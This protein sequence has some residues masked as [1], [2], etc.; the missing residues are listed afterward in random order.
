MNKFIKWNQVAC[1]VLLILS[2][3]SAARVS[4][5]IYNCSEVVPY[6]GDAFFCGYHETRGTVLFRS[7]GRYADAT[8]IAGNQRAGVN[9]LGAWPSGIFTLNGYLYYVAYDSQ[10][11][12]GLWRTDGKQSDPTLIYAD[13]SLAYA[14][15]VLRDDERVFLQTGSA[16]YVTG[17]SPTNTRKLNA[18]VTLEVSNLSTYWPATS[19]YLDGNT[20]WYVTYNQLHKLDLNANRSLSVVTLPVDSDNR[21]GCGYDTTLIAE[22]SAPDQIVMAHSISGCV[23][24]GTDPVELWISDGTQ[25]GTR[26]LFAEDTEVL[27][28]WQGDSLLCSLLDSAYYKLSNG[29][30]I[31]LAD[32]VDGGSECTRAKRG[33]NTNHRGTRYWIQQ[34]DSTSQYLLKAKNLASGESLTLLSVD[35][36]VTHII[37]D[38]NQLYLVLRDESGQYQLS[39]FSLASKE[40]THLKSFTHEDLMYAR[41]VNNQLFL[42]FTDASPS[43][44]S[45]STVDISFWKLLRADDEPTRYARIPSV[46][47]NNGRL[48]SWLEGGRMYFEIDGR[49]WHTAGT[50]DSTYPVV[51]RLEDLPPRPPHDLSP[52]IKIG[53]AINLLLLDDDED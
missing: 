46:K 31:K 51:Y 4:D 13:E 26:Q 40:Y 38:G 48:F 24:H 3:N 43:T 45:Q 12:T 42:I 15:V 22:G 21:N 20:L 1:L 49:Y 33:I 44:N 2:A 28:T 19:Y 35:E 25:S 39:R 37:P 9:D 17:G 53:P 36:Y 16:L 6:Q 32:G 29:R 10:L 14:S 34:D 8:V 41:Q 50:T 5:P 27:T 18:E 30:L 7:S 11:G 47:W 52:F 23:T